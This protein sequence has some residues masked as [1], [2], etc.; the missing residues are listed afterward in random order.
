[1]AP[2]TP[3]IS[4]NGAGEALGATAS[5]TGIAAILTSDADY[6]TLYQRCS[7]LIFV[8]SGAPTDA[9]PIGRQL[10]HLTGNAVSLRAQARRSTDDRLNDKIEVA[11]LTSF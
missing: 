9:G 1:M 10:S 2:S 8:A 5:P 11:E 3:C 7:P 6:G 4:S